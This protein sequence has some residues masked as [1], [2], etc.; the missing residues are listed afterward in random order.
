[1]VQDKSVNFEDTWSFL[2]RRFQDTRTFTECRQQADS[3]V[4][5]AYEFG[6]AA[7]TTVRDT[8]SGHSVICH[9]YS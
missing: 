5:G 4:G 3:T 8:M 6:T 2:R 7:I 9:F 1:M